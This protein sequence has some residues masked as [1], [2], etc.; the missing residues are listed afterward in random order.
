MERA[1]IYL[2]ERLSSL[3]LE[4]NSS[5]TSIKEINI[6]NDLKKFEEEQAEKLSHFNDIV[7]DKDKI[8]KLIDLQKQNEELLN[9]NNNF[10]ELLKLRERKRTFAVNRLISHGV[11]TSFSFLKEIA[12]NRLDKVAYLLSHLNK[13]KHKVKEIEKFN[14]IF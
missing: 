3:E 8:Y 9:D 1:L 14:E 2:Q 7:V 11:P 10:D 5:K 12:K 4:L 6:D 13:F